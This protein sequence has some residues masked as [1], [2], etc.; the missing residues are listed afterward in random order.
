MRLVS[1][2]MESSYL[3]GSKGGGDE[4]FGDKI[5]LDCVDFG[6]YKGLEIEHI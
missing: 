6:C 4:G 3:Q 5:V 2:L 1:D